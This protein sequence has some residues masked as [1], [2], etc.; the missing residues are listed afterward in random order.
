[1]IAL[2]CSNRA[3]LDLAAR[4]DLRCADLWQQLDDVQEQIECTIVA[5]GF[6]GPAYRNLLER[7][8]R[9]LR[10]LEDWS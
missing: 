4:I 8:R 3:T 2:R 6:N 7:E 5:P 10:E 9:I 1:M